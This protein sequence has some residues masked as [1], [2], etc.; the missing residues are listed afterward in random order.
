MP[1]QG[2]GRSM[3][4]LNS[5]AALSAKIASEGLPRRNP[6]QDLRCIAALSASIQDFQT[7]KQQGLK[8]SAAL[9][10]MIQSLQGHSQ[11]VLPS[12]TMRMNSRKKAPQRVRMQTRA[13]LI[14]IHVRCTSCSEI[15]TRSDRGE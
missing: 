10:A 1:S 14:L 3:Q 6:R 15:S 5:T 12:S 4:I 9:S 13:L 2:S 11:A 7:R 8:I